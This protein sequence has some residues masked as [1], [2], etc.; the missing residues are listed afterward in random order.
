[1]KRLKWSTMI[2]EVAWCGATEDAAGINANAAIAPASV[3]RK[4]AWRLRATADCSNTA[5]EARPRAIIGESARKSVPVNAVS[6][7]SGS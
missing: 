1:M 4:G 7:L 6:L 5:T 2:S 3:R